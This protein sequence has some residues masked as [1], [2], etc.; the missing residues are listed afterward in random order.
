MGHGRHRARRR[1]WSTW[2]A[3]ALILAGLALCAYPALA[4]SVASRRHAQVVAGYESA[5]ATMGDRRRE[6][7]LAEAR[8]HNVALAAAGSGSGTGAEE[9]RASGGTRY[10]SLLDPGGDGV[11]GVLVIPRIALRLPIYH[12]VG[13]AALA[14]GVGHMPDS[15]LPIGGAGTRS[16]L[17]G[18][19]GLPSAELF[20]RLD[21]LA[22][23]DRFAVIVL[24]ETRSYRVVDIRVV[25]AREVDDGSAGI[26]EATAA[27][28]AEASGETGGTSAVADDPLAPVPGRDLVTLVT[29][30]PYGVNTHRLLVTGERDPSGDGDAG[31]AGTASSRVMRVPTSLDS[32][33]RS[34]WAV[35]AAVLAI[36]AARATG[37][38]ARLIRGR[39]QKRRP[40][41]R[42]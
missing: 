39:K 9:R 36:G 20:T 5:T 25:E 26:T 11:M 7:M 34:G 13:E 33:F 31:L 37:M 22:R 2:P 12:G 32:W 15:A 24:G 8:R 27:A 10:A 30:T 21:E 42:P 14:K 29:C 1:F 35:A 16:V 3:V 17:A 40:C 18:H 23:G 41:G 4:E 19:R 28:D 38:M 6:S